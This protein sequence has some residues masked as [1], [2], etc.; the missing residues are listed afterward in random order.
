MALALKKK[1]KR[2]GLTGIEPGEHCAAPEEKAV[3]NAESNSVET[4]I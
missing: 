2:A 3:Y 1:I 4:A